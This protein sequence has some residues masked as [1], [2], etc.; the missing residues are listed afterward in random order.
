MNQ[1]VDAAVNKT[2]KSRKD[3]NTANGAVSRSTTGQ[4]HLDLFAIGGSARKE[5]L[6]KVVDLFSNAY[7]TDKVMALRLAFWI[8]D[9]RGGAGARQAFRNIFRWLSVNDAVV[10][11]MLIPFVAEFGR[12]DD[13]IESVPTQ[14]HLFTVA[15][16]ALKD[17]ID[18]GNALAAKW[19]PRKG[20]VAVALRTV[21]GMT[22]KAYRKYIVSR[23]T[24]VETLMCSKQWNAIEFDKLPSLAGLRY[25]SAFSR[26]ATKRYEEFKAKLVKGEVKI[27]AGTLFPHNIVA[28]IRH[29]VGDSTVLNAQWKALPDY[30]EGRSDRMLVLSDVSSSMDQTIGGNVTALDVSIALGLYMSERIEGPF[31]DLVMT[32]SENPYLHKVTG[33]N[34]STRIDNLECTPWGGNTD[35]QKAFD[36]ILDIALK[37]DVPQS[38]MPST[39][40]IVSDMEFD[41]CEG[42]GSNKTNLGGIK[43]KYKKAGYKMPNIVFWNVVGRA[44]NN[45]AKHNADG[46]ALV[47]GFSPAILGSI[48]SGKEDTF[49]INPMDVMLDAIMKERYDVAEL[50][51]R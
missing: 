4:A 13:V 44:G 1:F 50:A 29:R 32:F 10:A 23:T 3:A 21:W 2:T 27:N 16:A 20:D 41:R 49:E 43:D 33:V 45:Q 46:V 38:D 7:A 35:L 30:L 14:S 48:F 18:S 47:S 37:N 22:P 19:T 36:A 12:W 34:I 31:K 26:N 6:G 28:N 5:N 17:A 39:L 51:Q 8:R 40:V 24:V 9:V 42:Y 25:Q 11:E 15:A